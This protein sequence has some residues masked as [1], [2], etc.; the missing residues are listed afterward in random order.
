MALR[1]GL[2]IGPKRGIILA[3]T[4]KHHPEMNYLKNIFVKEAE[5][6]GITTL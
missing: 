6:T 5:Y 4:E 3:T 2:H 1:P